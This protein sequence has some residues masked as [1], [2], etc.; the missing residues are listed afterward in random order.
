MGNMNAHHTS[1]SL[2]GGQPSSNE[3]RWHCYNASCNKVWLVGDA[4]HTH[5]LGGRLDYV[6]LF[7][8]SLKACSVQQV[9]LCQII[10]H[11]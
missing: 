9:D 11:Y 2:S 5:T 7:N 1:L 4:E 8:E 3:Q 10:L 6:C